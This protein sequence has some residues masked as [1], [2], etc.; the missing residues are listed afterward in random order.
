MTEIDERMD[1]LLARYEYATGYAGRRLCLTSIR[2]EIDWAQAF[3]GIDREALLVRFREQ[4]VEL[5]SRS[6]LSHRD[7]RVVS[8]FLADR[9]C[10]GLPS[11]YFEE[12]ATPFFFSDRGALRPGPAA[13]LLA[14][15]L[16]VGHESETQ[17]ARV[18]ADLDAME[19]ME[20]F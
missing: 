19:C 4:Y 5:R 16:V 15:Y 12:H 3:G 11:F 18:E 6:R 17:S 9:L 8:E 2:R 14:A 13:Y 10:R 7:F 20:R 1:D